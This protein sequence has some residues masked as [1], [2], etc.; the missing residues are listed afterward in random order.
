M[1][2]YSRGENEGA[3]YYNTATVVPPMAR[4]LSNPIPMTMQ[5]NTP[6]LVLKNYM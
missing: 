6:S 4:I 2:R 5:N 3:F 1:L